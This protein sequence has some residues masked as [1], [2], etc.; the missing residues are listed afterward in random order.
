MTRRPGAPAAGGCWWALVACM[1]AEGAARRVNQARV[2]VC[3]DLMG[4]IPE[5]RQASAPSLPACR[6]RV[7]SPEGRAARRSAAGVPC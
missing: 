6:T 1:Q 5:G 3:I 4:W 7:T 2:H